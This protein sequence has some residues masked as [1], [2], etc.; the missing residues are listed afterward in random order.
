MKQAQKLMVE[1][2]Q[3]SGALKNPPKPIQHSFKQIQTVNIYSRLEKWQKQPTSST[4]NIEHRT[5]SADLKIMIE[6]VPV[7]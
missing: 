3:A 5:V 1:M 7:V 4:G 6:A 2:L